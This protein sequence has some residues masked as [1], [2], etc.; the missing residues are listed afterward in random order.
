MLNFLNN[1]ISLLK[2]LNSGADNMRRTGLNSRDP[3]QEALVRN[4]V[5]EN[6]DLS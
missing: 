2:C 5:S 3:Y 6:E 4:P 1:Q